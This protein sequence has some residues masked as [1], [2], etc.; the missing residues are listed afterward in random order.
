MVAFQV[1]ESKDKQAPLISLPGKKRKCCMINSIYKEVLMKKQFYHV[2][3]LV[4][5]HFKQKFPQ[6][7][8][9]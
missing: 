7:S 2:D 5:E 1:V 8:S 9:C 6:L 3:Q 4:I